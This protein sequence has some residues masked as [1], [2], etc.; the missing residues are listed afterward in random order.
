MSSMQ[1]GEMWPCLLEKALAKVAGGYHR[2]IGGDW[3]NAL[4]SARVMS[5]LIGS[6]S[7]AVETVRDLDAS[8]KDASLPS[9]I[10]EHL[11][12]GDVITASCRSRDNGLVDHHAYSVLSL[13]CLQVEGEAVYVIR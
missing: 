11:A 8:A 3:K 13:H 12:H 5:L 6:Q 10:F 2:L 7:V 1:E 4:G 9:F